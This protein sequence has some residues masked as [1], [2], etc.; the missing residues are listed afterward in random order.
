MFE[1]SVAAGVVSGGS[2]PVT[3]PALRS[4]PSAPDVA[5]VV[6]AVERVVVAARGAD[7]WSVGERRAVLAGLDRVIDGLSAVRAAVLVAER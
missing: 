1:S 3:G 5:S 6:A 2:A 7:G 4:S